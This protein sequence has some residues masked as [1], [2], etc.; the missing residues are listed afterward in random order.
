MQIKTFAIVIILASLLAGS[1]FSH[2][3]STAPLT[4]LNLA[5][6]PTVMDAAH[7]LETI[8]LAQAE[9]MLEGIDSK[10]LANI[11]NYLALSASVLK[12][13]PPSGMTIGDQVKLI[14]KKLRLV[15]SIRTV[16]TSRPDTAPRPNY[17]PQ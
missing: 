2:A 10:E 1:R 12:K 13:N 4:E 3:S 6:N 14:D 9:Q 15:D 8:D 17:I 16:L 5:I 11:A 7:T